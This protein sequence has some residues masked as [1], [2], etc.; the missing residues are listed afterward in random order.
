VFATAG[1]ARDVVLSGGFAYVADDYRGFTVMDVHDPLKPFLVANLGES[2]AQQVQVSGGRAFVYGDGGDRVV[3]YDISVPSAPVQLAVLEEVRSPLTVSG[4]LGFFA[5]SGLHVYDVT[6][7]ARST[8][9]GVYPLGCDPRQIA[10]IG[11]TA[12]VA[13]GYLGLAILDVSDPT[14]PR[15]LANYLS[16]CQ[17]RSSSMA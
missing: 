7:P 1:Y 10:V 13:N 14:K 17:V 12:L 8:R 11:Q 2:Y 4:N 5:A 9:I 16:E 3:V 15:E 6:D